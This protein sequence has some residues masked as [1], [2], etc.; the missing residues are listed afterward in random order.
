MTPENYLSQLFALLPRGPAWPRKPDSVLG[1][2]LAAAAAMFARV[3]NR[4]GSMIDE[5]D[6]RT[7]S[8]LLPEF[9]KMLGLPEPCVAMT[10]ADQTIEQRRAA[11]VARL[12]EVGGASKAFFI[13]V[14]KK[15]GYPDAVIE[16]YRPMNCNDD[17]NDALWS[18][19]DRWTWQISVPYDDAGVFIANCNSDCNAPLKQW[20][21]AGF[22]CYISQI[23][24]AETEV[25]FA[26]PK[27]LGETVETH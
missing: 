16:T 27:N 13:A 1:R 17:C 24:P 14:A 8:W 25:V 15:L 7:T 20:G 11:V 10:G 12:T 19:W 4:A 26:Y 6:P 2:V 22:E 21:N 23:K 18:E 5:A 3:D 9:E